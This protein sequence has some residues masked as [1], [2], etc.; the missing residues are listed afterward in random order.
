MPSRRPTIALLI[1]TT[2]LVSACGSTQTSPTTPPSQA[3]APSAS[4]VA[5]ASP[6]ASLAAEPSPT[7]EPS[8]AVDPTATPEATP[9]AAPT[10]APTATPWKRFTSAR[11]RYTVKYPPDWVVTKGSAK[12]ADQIDDYTTHFVFLSR[13]TVSGIAS[14]NLTVSHDIAY[15][16]SHYKA[17]LASN[18]K[19]TVNG[20][21][22]RLLTFNGSWSGR[23]V[24]IQHLILAKG[25]VGYIVDM[26]SDQGAAVADKA[27][28]KKI[29]NTFRPK[30]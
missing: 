23:K 3:A 10:P 28:F 18:Q 27:L 6:T 4:T 22:G 8:A 11:Y 16:K 9:T 26:F 25:K 24:Y 15:M 20:W 19:V 14:V 5:E 12:L 21:P 17:R 2:V 7:A 1:A 29:Y 13:D 30:S